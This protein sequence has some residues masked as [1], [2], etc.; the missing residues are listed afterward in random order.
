MENQIQAREILPEN[1]LPLTWVDRLIERFSIMY[2]EKFTKQWENINPEML[3]QAWA[4][5]LAGF[6]GDEIKSGIDACKTKSWP[7]TLPEFM[8]LCR[9]ALDKERAYLE[10]AEQMRIRHS[11]G[12]DIWSAPAIYWAASRIGNDIQ[13]NPY[14]SMKARWAATLD[15]VNHE[16]SQGLLANSVPAFEKREELPPPGKTSVMQE[17]AKNRIASVVSGLNRDEN[18]DYKGWA[19]KVVENQKDYPERSL[20]LAKEALEAKA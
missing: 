8:Q 13:T 5:E 4:E 16:I 11:T 19:K 9:P 2:G 18:Y 17:E 1:A 20:K 14:Q 15:K 7:P 10:A 6:T 12:E 3:R